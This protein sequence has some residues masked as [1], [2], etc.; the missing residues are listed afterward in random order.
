MN[1]TILRMHEHVDWR[2]LCAGR[3]I[4]HDHELQRHIDYWLKRRKLSRTATPDEIVDWAVARQRNL[5]E[6]AARRLS[7]GTG[8]T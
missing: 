8:C 7:H 1:A 2:T 4:D 5:A 6:Q 3:G